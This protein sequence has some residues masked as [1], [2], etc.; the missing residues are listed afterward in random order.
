MTHGCGRSLPLALGLEG[1]PLGI[2]S[3]G[4]RGTS[5]S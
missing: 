3:V 2:G 4:P 5:G 1:A